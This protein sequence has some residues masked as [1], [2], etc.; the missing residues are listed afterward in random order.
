MITLDIETT[1]A[2]DHI[3]CCGLHI[4]GEKRVSVLRNPMQIVDRCSR[5]LSV[6]DQVFVGHNIVNFDAPKLKEL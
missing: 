4:T 6:R 5:D 2:M 1:M 3:W